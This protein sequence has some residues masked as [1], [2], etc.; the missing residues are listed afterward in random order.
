MASHFR[1][2]RTVPN[3]DPGGRY[4]LV[5]RN[6]KVQ[7]RR[8]SIKL[9]PEIWDALAEICRREYCTTRDLCSYVAEHGQGSLASSLRIFILDYFHASA[10][11]D[12]HRNAE[13][14]QGM[15]L[16]ERQLHLAIR[17]N[18][19]DC[20]EPAMGRTTIYGWRCPGRFRLDR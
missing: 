16:S 9:E 11:E 10:T 8:T 12:G 19:A 4:A 2:C 17:A 6:I 14:G 18:K 1:N 7:G 13:H 20:R 5:I 15:F 3:E